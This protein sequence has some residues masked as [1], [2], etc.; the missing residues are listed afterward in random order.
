MKIKRYILLIIAIIILVYS[1]AWNLYNKRPNLG[2]TRRADKNLQSHTGENKNREGPISQTGSLEVGDYISNIPFHIPTD[3]G[4][5]YKLPWE[6]DRDFLQVQGQHGT[7]VLLAGFATVLKSTFPGEKHNVH[8]ATR[9]ASGTIIAPGH[10]FSQNQI[11]GPYTESRGYQEGLAYIGGA[12]KPSI[13]GGVCKVASTLY[14]VAILSNLEIVERYNH[15]MPVNYLPYGQDAT[16]AYGFKDLKF[17]NNTDYPILIWA[18]PIDNIIYIAFYGK[19]KPAKIEWD[20]NILEERKTF[21]KYQI[22][23][24]LDKGEERI[25]IKGMDGAVVE[26]FINIEYGDGRIERKR[27]GISSYWPMPHIV[28]VNDLKVE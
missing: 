15:S 12:V 26:S 21:A 5:I 27:L 19:E 2:R 9:S 11:I 3:S 6:R 23:N 17:K 7:D 28:E 22:N 13:G 24:D 10:I 18:L 8:L 1:V 16:V 4:P 20:H 14:N 25:I